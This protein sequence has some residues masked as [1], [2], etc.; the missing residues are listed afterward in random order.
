M[1]NYTIAMRPYCPSGAVRN[2]ATYT[3]ESC[4]WEFGH[5]TPTAQPTG[6]ECLGINFF[7]SLPA[8][9]ITP[10]QYAMLVYTLCP[11]YAQLCSAVWEERESILKHDAAFHDNADALITASQ[12]FRFGLA[13]EDIPHFSSAPACDF[14]FLNSPS[15]NKRVMWDGNSWGYVG[16]CAT[17]GGY[18][19]A[20]LNLVPW[21]VCWRDW[22]DM[23]AIHAP[24]RFTRSVLV[25]ARLLLRADTKDKQFVNALRFL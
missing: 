9:D 24:E 5:G 2:H 19:C 20:P 23:S 4:D 7:T 6:E 3:Q 11:A 15:L 22:M 13:I 17:E 25:L 14:P 10:E 1:S 16:G 18:R 21:E 12:G 8:I